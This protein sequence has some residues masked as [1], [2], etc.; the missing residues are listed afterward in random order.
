MDS[1]RFWAPGDGQATSFFFPLSGVQERQSDKIPEKFH[2]PIRILASFGT[3]APG[4]WDEPLASEV[5]AFPNLELGFGLTGWPQNGVKIGIGTPKWLACFWFP[6]KT[7]PE[8]DLLLRGL[9]TPHPPLD[10]PVRSKWLDRAE[11]RTRHGLRHLRPV[12]ATRS[13]SLGRMRLND[14]TTG[15]RPPVRLKT[16]QLRQSHSG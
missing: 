16:T 15:R 8:G 3:L 4:I 2:H 13:A 6:W 7:A 11:V 9:Q 14:W 1:S 10:P 5:G 12:A